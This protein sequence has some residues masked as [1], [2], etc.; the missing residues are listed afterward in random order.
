M[1]L[2]TQ[3]SKGQLYD[4]EN[5]QRVRHS[6]ITFAHACG[7]PLEAM[8]LQAE[9]KRSPDEG[10]MIIFKQPRNTK[11]FSGGWPDYIRPG[12]DLKRL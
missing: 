10:A 3:I 9:S 8:E 11:H 6:R 2:S 4:S 1:Y 5:C 12:Q 7:E